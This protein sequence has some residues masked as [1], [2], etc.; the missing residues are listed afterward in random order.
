MKVK[1]VT[2]KKVACLAGGCPAA[3]ET[4][5]GTYLII[6]TKVDSSED[7]LQGNIGTGE[8]VIEVPADL[9]RL[10]K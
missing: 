1:E 10:L 6:G 2:P 4:D 7:L 9:I 8:A 3:F 5:R